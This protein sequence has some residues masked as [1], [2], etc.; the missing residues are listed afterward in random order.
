MRISVT[1]VE[2]FRLYLDTEW[3][4]FER[5]KNQL[6]EGFVTTPIIER[7]SSFHE[8]METE[9]S[10]R[11]DKYGVFDKTKAYKVN[12]WSWSVDDIDRIESAG[13]DKELKAE[14]KFDLPQGEAILVGKVDRIKDMIIEDYKVT[15]GAFMAD[16]YLNSCQWKYYCLMFGLPHFRYRV[17]QVKKQ[18]E[19][20]LVKIKEE[21]NLDCHIYN[22][23]EKELNNLLEMFVDFCIK[24]EFHKAIGI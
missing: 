21:H 19:P 22:G 23:M 13:G 16:K 20:G 18:K 4:T 8:L 9:P 12:D 6:T 1:T 24:N 2:S 17:V 11:W 15:E 10:D 7:G 14:I 3:M 5:L